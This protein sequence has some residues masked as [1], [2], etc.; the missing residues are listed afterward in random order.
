VLRES[1]EIDE[2][3]GTT[4]DITERRHAEAAL[5]KAQDELRQSQKMEAI[6]R[7]AGGVAHDFNNLLGVIIGYSELVQNTLHRGSLQMEHVEQIGKAAEQAASLTRNLLTFSRRQMPQTKV[8]DLQVLLSGL[9]KMLRSVVGEDIEL[10]LETDS[11]PSLIRSDPGQIEQAILNLVIN[12]RDAMPSG[13]K[14]AISLSRIVL[15]EEF[16]RVHPKAKP[17]AYVRLT[18]SDTGCGMDA[19]TQARIFEPFFTTKDLGKGTG[20]GLATV[21]GTIEQTGGMIA[22][23]SEPEHGTSFHLYIPQTGEA[24]APPISI[25]ADARTK[26]GSETILLVEDQDEIRSLLSLILKREGY[27]VLA[28]RNGREALLLAQNHPAPIDLMIT[29]IVMPQMSGHELACEMNARRPAMKV[30][31]MS[32][33]ADRSREQSKFSGSAYAYLEKPFSPDAMMREV[34]AIL[35][36][37]NILGRSA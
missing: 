2:Y 32:G 34:R 8:V 5:Q 18:V 20:L 13:G 31:Y 30:L 1:G 27:V 6:G 28:A 33:Y 19:A 17:G 3:I 16:A 9:E 14:L 7:L 37:P 22:V 4:M 36:T 21:Y 24:L 10:T 29:D 35:D 12:A 23:E 11:T 25:P 15:A 26:G